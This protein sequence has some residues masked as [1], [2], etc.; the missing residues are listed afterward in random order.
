MNLTGVAS[1][2][3]VIGPKEND[4]GLGSNSLGR[5]MVAEKA[6]TTRMPTIESVRIAR[7]KVRLRALGGDSFVSR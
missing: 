3:R 5:R 7:G 4:A 1:Y 2:S 6:V